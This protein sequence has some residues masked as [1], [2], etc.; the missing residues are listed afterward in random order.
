[1]LNYISVLF[2]EVKYL[3]IH[4][5]LYSLYI[6]KSNDIIDSITCIDGKHIYSHNSHVARTS[7]IKIYNDLTKCCQPIALGAQGGTTPYCL[8]KYCIVITEVEKD[9]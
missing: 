9:C 5:H 7:Q 8:Y 1:M 6:A 2:Y 4:I 3:Y